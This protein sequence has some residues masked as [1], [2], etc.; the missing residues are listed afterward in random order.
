MAGIDRKPHVGQQLTGALVQARPVDDAETGAAA[1]RQPTE[2]DV[3]AD[4]EL[5]HQRELLVH[6]D[7]AG[8]KGVVRRGEVA[9]L[10]IDADRARCRLGHAGEK[11]DQRRLA[12]AVLAHEGMHLAGCEAVGEFGEGDSR[13]VTLGHGPKVQPSLHPLQRG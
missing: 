11:L 13:A 3:L 2:K 4:R 12:R 7:N 1:V 10:A 9:V 5:R 8:G 6:G